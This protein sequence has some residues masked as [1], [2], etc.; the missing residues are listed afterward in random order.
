MDVYMYT[1]ASAAFI[2]LMG[3]QCADGPYHG[4]IRANRLSPSAW[5]SICTCA[6][7][8]YEGA[9]LHPVI[10]ST[11]IQECICELRA[12]AYSLRCNQD[13]QHAVLELVSYILR[14]IKHH[15]LRGVQARVGQ[16]GD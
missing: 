2:S 15:S 4:S 12:A 9:G 13:M 11:K 10:E 8:T 5:S 7:T 1:S 3:R 14:V 16:T 6:G